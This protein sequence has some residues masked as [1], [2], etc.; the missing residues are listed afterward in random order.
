MIICGLSLLA[1]GF[2]EMRI[3]TDVTRLTIRAIYNVLLVRISPLTQE[4]E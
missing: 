4:D 1:D 2:D 3:D